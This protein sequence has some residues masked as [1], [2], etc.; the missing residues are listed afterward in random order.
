MMMGRLYDLDCDCSSLATCSCAAAISPWARV[1]TPAATAPRTD[2]FTKS[3]R[4]KVMG[5]SCLLETGKHITRRKAF[6]HGGI[7]RLRSG[8]APTQR[9]S[10]VVFSSSF[11]V[12][13]VSL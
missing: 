4:E 10:R 6:H 13:S 11:L 2:V 5:S 8:Q 9:K 12:F 7:L 1:P 3:R